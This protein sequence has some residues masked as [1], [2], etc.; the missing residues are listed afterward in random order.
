MR[1]LPAFFYRDP[2]EGVDELRAMRASVERCN[3]REREV[4]G[5]KLKHKQPSKVERR[6][7]RLRIMSMVRGVLESGGGDA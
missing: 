2:A 4:T 6:H 1:A 5:E 3:Q 7:K